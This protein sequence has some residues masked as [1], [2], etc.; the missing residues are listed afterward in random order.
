MQHMSNIFSTSFGINFAKL[1]RVWLA[2]ISLT[3]KINSLLFWATLYT[4]SID[5]LHKIAHPKFSPYLFPNKRHN[6]QPEYKKSLI[7]LSAVHEY[8]QIQKH[9]WYTFS[10]TTN[11]IDN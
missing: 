2:L 10:F 9:I 8:T 11:K 1:T 3:A 5:F 4:I 7:V 6:S